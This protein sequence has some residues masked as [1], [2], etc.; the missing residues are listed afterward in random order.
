MTAPD[1]T[2]PA[3]VS[4]ASL[5]PIRR[6]ERAQVAAARMSD[7]LDEPPDRFSRAF[8]GCLA[9]ICRSQPNTLF[10]RVTGFTAE[11]VPH[12]RAIVEWFDSH[13]V[14]PRI[15]L[16]PPLSSPA[17][18][19]TLE[20]AGLALDDAKFLTRRVVYGVIAPLAEA[21]S[22]S[23][24]AVTVHR[25]DIRDLTAF[26]EIQMTI[27]PDDGGTRDD[28]LA[29]L[30]GSAGNPGLIRYLATVDGQPAATAAL[31][32]HDRV[33]WLSAGATLPGFRGRG[34]QTALIR[35]RLADAHAAGC[36]LAASLVAA[37]SSSERN[38]R[39][40]GLATAFDREVWMRPDW[41]SHPF[42]RDAG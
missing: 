22:P 40:A 24:R 39:R 2:P 19:S 32:I 29:R 34:C 8:G 36:D 12:L 26:L 23:P 4:S 42:Y 6:V 1:P 31:A 21:D 9:A 15:D 41:M 30:H 13:G 27:W 16:A 35:S 11:D 5:E 37:G 28:R 10:N 14:P 7:V 25:T 33:A 17:T 38:L 18:S 20:A 3:D